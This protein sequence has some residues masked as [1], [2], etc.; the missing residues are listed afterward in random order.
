MDVQKE[1]HS[2]SEHINQE[3]SIVDLNVDDSRYGQ[4]EE[5]LSRNY[6]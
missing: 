6:C 3:V 5:S 2:I 1:L 4:L